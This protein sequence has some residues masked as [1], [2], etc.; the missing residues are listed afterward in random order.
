VA[1]PR[2][3]PGA[4][5][6]RD[7]VVAKRRAVFLDRDGVINESIVR[8]GKPYA[9][10]SLDGFK[11]LPGVKEALRSL[12]EAGFLNIVVTNQPDVATG[13]AKREDID[14][15]HAELRKLPIDAVKVCFHDDAQQCACRKPRPGLLLEAAE[16]FGV[17]L[18]SSFLVGDRWR[19]VGA[20]HAAGCTALFV[21]YRYTERR[22]DPPYMEVK[23]LPEAAALIIRSNK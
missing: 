20:A 15:I 22:P 4:P 1:L 12:R 7:E 3:Q 13:K 16:E 8:D 2:L 17:D 14:A 11:L 18:P 9:P 5:A 21:D 6:N 10:R 19:D 23:S